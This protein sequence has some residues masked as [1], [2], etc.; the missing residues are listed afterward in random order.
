MHNSHKQH[1][2]YIQKHS[3]MKTF[4]NYRV[5]ATSEKVFSKVKSFESV[6]HC[7]L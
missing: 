6:P 4:V 3:Q 5:L 2:M 1:T 7:F